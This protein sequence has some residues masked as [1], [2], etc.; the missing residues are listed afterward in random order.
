MQLRADA[1]VKAKDKF[2]KAAGSLSWKKDKETPAEETQ[3]I[4]STLSP[5][6]A[7]GGAEE[8][9]KNLN[10]NG[11]GG[12]GDKEKTMNVGGSGG[13]SKTINIKIEQ[14][15]YF[16]IDRSVGSKDAVA[17]GVITK[18]NDRMRDALVTI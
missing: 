7:I 15:N 8:S 10:N 12:K 18:L 2:V 16:T 13:G 1:H 17:N 14:K 3:K 5:N 11:K 6:A 4:A 9:W